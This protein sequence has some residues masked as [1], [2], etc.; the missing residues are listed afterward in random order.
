M[1]VRRALL[2]AHRA[3]QLKTLIGGWYDA[4]IAK[5]VKLEARVCREICKIAGAEGRQQIALAT[6]KTVQKLEEVTG[7]LEFASLLQFAHTMWSFGHHSIAQIQLEMAINKT[8]QLPIACDETDLC[9]ALTQSVSSFLTW[10]ARA[11]C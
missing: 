4:A 3:Q 1:Q 7:H 10:R 9:E 11:Y 2:H 8:S 6:S 5:S